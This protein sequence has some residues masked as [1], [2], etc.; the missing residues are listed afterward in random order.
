M[1]QLPPLYPLTD[2][3]RAASLSEQVKKFGEAGLPLVQFRGKPLDAKAQYEELLASLRQ[4][5]DNGGWPMI[6]VNDR[7]DLAVL[8]ARE[9]LAPWGLHLGQ[10]DLPPWEAR[11]LPGLDQVHLGTSTHVETEWTSVDGACDHAGVGPFRAT[12]TKPDH[13]PP[14]GLDGLREGCTALR[15]K[16]ISP[17]AIGGVARDDFEDVFTAGAESA[18]LLCELDR[19]DPAE[20]AWAAQGARWKARPP[21]RRGQ[22]VA[23]VGSSGSGKSTLASA[24]GPRLGLPVLDLDTRIAATAGRSIADIFELRG[25]AEFRRLEV[26]CL[27]ANLHQPS[28]LALGGGAWA[29]PEIRDAL[30]TA[31]FAVLWIAETP[32][33]C[34]SRIAADPSRPLAKDRDE[35]LRRHLLRMRHWRGLPMVLPLGRGADEIAE[36]AAVALD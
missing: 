32:A 13:E 15:S 16:G 30:G 10:K 4:A 11:K 31:G 6:C 8:A 22:G 29:S 28:V 34:W 25:E 20:L 7:A 17:I 21:F 18:A 14:I 19:S 35:F 3:R 26:E 1:I 12:A 2:P 24:L 33:A 27:R 5:H 23:L 36:K 9:G